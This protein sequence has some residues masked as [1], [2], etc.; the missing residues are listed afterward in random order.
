MSLQARSFATP[1]AAAPQKLDWRL[2]L[3][4]VIIV[5]R[6]QRRCP[7]DPAILPA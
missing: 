5:S 6:E 3:L 4:I 1:E 7:A 2:I